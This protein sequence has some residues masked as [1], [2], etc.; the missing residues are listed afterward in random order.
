MP[1]SAA[2]VSH[3]AA[4]LDRNLNT[5]GD[6]ARF[7]I[8]PPIHPLDHKYVHLCDM[9]SISDVKSERE[10]K[11]TSR[12]NDDMIKEHKRITTEESG[13]HN[14]PCGILRSASSVETYCLPESWSSQL[15]S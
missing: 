1:T 9:L 15:R 13:L 6:L 11:N 12:K 10:N 14:S 2:W 3:W 4:T 7:Q 5:W 8:Y